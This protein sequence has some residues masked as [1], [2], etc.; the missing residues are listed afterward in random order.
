[1][2]RMFGLLIILGVLWAGI[3]FYTKGDQAFGGMFASIDAPAAAED[4]PWAGERAGARLRGGHDERG[5]RMER[6]LGE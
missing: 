2:E 3:E 4:A 5:D 1:M 6:A